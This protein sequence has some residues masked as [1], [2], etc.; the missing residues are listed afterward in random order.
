MRTIT[1]ISLLTILITWSCSTQNDSKNDDFSIV[2]V[3]VKHN[4]ELSVTVWNIEVAGKA[5][6]STPKPIGQLDGAS[7]FGYVFPTTIKPENVGFNATE[8]IVALALT[9][10]PDFDDTPLWDE[11]ADANYN[12]DGVI[13][14]PHW[15]ILVE[16]DRVSGG[17][18]IKQF[19][20]GD[21]SVILPP[22]NPGMPMYMDSPG[23]PVTTRNGLISVVVPDYRIKN[24]TSFNFD[25]VAAYMKVNTSKPNLPML[26][27]YEVHSIA[28]GDLSLPYT[29]N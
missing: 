27:V 5:G 18:S 2:S 29:V 9:S 21:T 28:S 26:G 24:E 17:F 11:N 19:E 7:V 23:Y 22:T 8:G 4:P 15:V 25:A 3:N 10:H 20:A 1:Y 16:D 6:A 13:W 12:N 14:H